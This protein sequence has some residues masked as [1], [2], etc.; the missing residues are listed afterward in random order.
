MVN[1]MYKQKF[2]LGVH[3]IV[4]FYSRPDTGD[5]GILDEKLALATNQS[6]PKLDLDCEEKN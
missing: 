5:T 3:R 4:F 1:R 2:R 6:L